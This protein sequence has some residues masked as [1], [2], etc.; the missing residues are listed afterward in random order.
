MYPNLKMELWRAG[1]RQNSLAKMLHVDETILSRILN[2][3]R[4]PSPELRNRIASL[5][6]KDESW[7]F[8]RL[9]KGS[10]AADQESVS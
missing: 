10:L 8:E 6:Q 1:I 4:Y 7:L 3:Y 5:L 2:G 9:H